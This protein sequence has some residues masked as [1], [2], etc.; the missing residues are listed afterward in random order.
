MI[1]EQFSRLLS[2]L[3]SAISMLV[4]KAQVTMVTDGNNKIQRVQLDLGNNQIGVN[5]ERVQNFGFSSNPKIGAETMVLSLNGNRDH[6]VAITVDDSRFRPSVSEGDSIQYN[7]TGVKVHCLGL[8]INFSG[9]RELT[10]LDGLVTG[11]SVDP[12]TGIPY[13]LLPGPSPTGRNVSD[14]V[15]G[16]L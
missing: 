16:E 2:P 5:V 6:M 1:L 4:S 11:L 15:R 3:K 13:H 14:I 8:T 7:S 9:T 10:S 12:G